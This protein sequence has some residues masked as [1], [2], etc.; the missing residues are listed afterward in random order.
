MKQ[1]LE[2]FP[3]EMIAKQLVLVNSMYSAIIPHIASSWKLFTVPVSSVSRAALLEVAA[4]VR[5]WLKTSPPRKEMLK[6]KSMEVGHAKN[7]FCGAAS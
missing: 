5:N 6:A 2:D 7:Q 3:Q 4:N 1:Y